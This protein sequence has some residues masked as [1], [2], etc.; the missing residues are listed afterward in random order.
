MEYTITLYPRQPNGNIVMNAKSVYN[1]LETNE[2][3]LIDY[4][5]SRFPLGH[6]INAMIEICAWTPQ[7][8][9]PL[10]EA[11]SWGKLLVSLDEISDTENIVQITV[12]KKMV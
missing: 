8:G 12:S 6:D 5:K 9:M 11:M 10:V 4:I 7:K 1:A 2:A 3:A